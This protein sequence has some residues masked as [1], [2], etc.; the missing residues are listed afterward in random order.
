[1]DRLCFSRRRRAAKVSHSRCNSAKT[2]KLTDARMNV[3]SW[4]GLVESGFMRCGVWWRMCEGSEQK[5]D[6]GAGKLLSIAWIYMRQRQTTVAI[7]T[8][9]VYYE[10]NERPSSSRF[11]DCVRF[12]NLA[13]LIVNNR[14]Q[15]MRIRNISHWTE[16]QN[17]RNICQLLYSQS[18]RQTG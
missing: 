12:R 11:E 9:N 13:S 1:M 8:R 4:D 15:P 3:A 5:E 6:P 7:K 2:L 17:F 18:P 10:W 14:C 16:F